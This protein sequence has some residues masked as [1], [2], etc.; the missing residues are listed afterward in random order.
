MNKNDRRVKKT[1]KALQNALAKLMI[2]KNLQNITVQE[3]SD[4]ADVHRATFY[5]H[6]HD[7][8]D[9]YEQ[10]E[11]DMFSELNSII[12]NDPTHTYEKLFENLINYIYDNSI[13]CQ[14][15]FSKNGSRSFQTNI[16]SLLEEK[17]K[18]IYKFE[19]QR[20][21]VSEEIDFLISYHIYGCIAV[22]SRWL[23]HN[24]S[25]PKD[26]MKQLI[27][28]IDCNADILFDKQDGKL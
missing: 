8:Y 27:V 17:Y 1:K 14:M 24:L 7:I 6:Y 4:I 11:K 2:E 12:D 19:E 21:N 28:N 25:Y 18:Q 3:L 10:I 20:T 16:F 26:K 22:V 23:E 13:L 5:A 15:L 9:L